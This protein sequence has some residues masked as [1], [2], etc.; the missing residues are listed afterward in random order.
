VPLARWSYAEIARRLVALGVVVSIAAS[1][2]GRWLRAERVK[3]WRY[4]LWQH[5]RDPRFLE[6]AKPV[7]RLYEL[8][9]VLYHCGVWVVCTDEKTSIQA[10]EGIDAPQPAAAGQPQHLAARYER[11]GALQLFAGLS[12]A[13]GQVFGCCRNR[14]CFVDFQAFIL[15]V[16][17]PEAVRR[18]VRV[19]CL[20]LDNG[21]THAPKQLEAWLVKQQALHQWPF[22]IKLFWLPKYASWLDQVEIWFSIL[23][24][25]VLSPNHF[26]SVAHLKRVLLDFIRY[27]N[28]TAKPIQWSYTI[29]K[30]EKKFGDPTQNSMVPAMLELIDQLAAPQLLIPAYTIELPRLADQNFR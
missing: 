9:Q 24:R 2:I 21:P 8:A 29:A 16:L 1:T 27:H 7:L 14:R 20:I 6:L 3:P 26:E 28:R 22:E 19:I 17:V 15:D 18:G 5:V 13:E 23:Q 11:R 10:R 30:L 12:V 25:K 4:H